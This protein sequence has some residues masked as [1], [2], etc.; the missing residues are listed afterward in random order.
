MFMIDGLAKLTNI[1]TRIYYDNTNIKV[2]YNC[3]CPG[4]LSWTRNVGIS[5]TCEPC[6]GVQFIMLLRIR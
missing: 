4:K 1:H 6:V 3:V 5:K 2:R